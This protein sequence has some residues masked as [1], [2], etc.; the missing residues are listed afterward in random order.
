MT[1][2][3]LAESA[4][5]QLLETTSK[6]VSAA[7][8]LGKPAYVLVLDNDELRIANEAARLDG[9]E[10]VLLA[11]HQNPDTISFDQISSLLVALM[12]NYQALIAS[13]SGR[14][15]YVLPNLAAKLETAPLT[16]VS[17]ILDKNLFERPVY[18]SAAIERVRLEQG[19]TL[20]TIRTAPFECVSEQ[21]PCEIEPIATS[22]SRMIRQTSR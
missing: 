10:K 18:A 20:L 7:K 4:D 3:V 5:H 6:L 11:S 16:G 19:K 21:P 2:L 15:K 12:D 22:V 9:V 17:A 8:A 1:T 14:G 13:A